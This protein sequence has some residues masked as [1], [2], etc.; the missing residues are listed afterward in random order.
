MRSAV[1][2]KGEGASV[3]SAP[4]GLAIGLAVIAVPTLAQRVRTPPHATPQASPE[5]DPAV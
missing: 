1:E 3:A 2:P 4:V 5:H